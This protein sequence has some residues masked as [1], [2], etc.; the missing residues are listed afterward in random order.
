MAGTAFYSVF[1]IEYSSNK[2]LRT[3]FK[4]NVVMDTAVTK[5]KIHLSIKWEST[6]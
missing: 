2:Y 4:P 3:K 6:S 5:A 1:G